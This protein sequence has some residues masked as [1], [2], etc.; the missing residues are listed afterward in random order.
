MNWHWTSIDKLSEVSRG[1]FDTLHDPNAQSCPFLQ[2]AFLHAF[3]QTKCVGEQSGWLPSHIVVRDEENKLIAF[4]P[5]YIK[6]HSYG[7]YVFDHSW[8]NAYEQHGLAYY[9]KLIIALP[10]TPVTAAR[11]LIA[12]STNIAKVTQYIGDI[13]ESM[14]QKLSISSIHI[15]F[16]D[17]QSASELLNHGFHQ[18]M[19]VQ[20]NWHNKQYSH[21]DDFM[22]SL[23]ARRRRSIKKERKGITKQGVSV[24]RVAGDNISQQDIDFFYTC[25]QQTY[26]KRSGHTGYLN[27]EF[28][29]ALLSNMPQNM[30]LVIAQKDLTR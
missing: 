8:A 9:P 30:M 23:T 24:R 18:R 19:S 27:H 15:L 28:F 2:Y 5:A 13:K 10:F 17:E 1:E 4:L 7:E 29:N 22:A 16:P 11:A 26:L 21:F 6:T 20:F 14:M 3:E 12:A 25:Y